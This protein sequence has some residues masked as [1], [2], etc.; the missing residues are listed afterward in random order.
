MTVYLVRSTYSRRFIA[1]RQVLEAYPGA[2]AINAY[3]ADA[4]GFY[5]GG[6]YNICHSIP[7]EKR[8]GTRTYPV[9]ACKGRTIEPVRV[10]AVESW[11][12]V[13]VIVHDCTAHQPRLRQRSTLPAEHHVIYYHTL[14]TYSYIV[15]V[16]GPERKMFLASD[17]KHKRYLVRRYSYIPGTCKMSGM[18]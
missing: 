10:T 9:L 1:P 12:L 8:V 16:S 5:A 11:G 6:R 3:E 18:Q 2:Y 15:R 17:E 14:E 13:R 7:D 4:R